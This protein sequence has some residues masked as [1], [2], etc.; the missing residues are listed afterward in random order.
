LHGLPINGGLTGAEA[1]NAYRILQ[2]FDPTLA[3]SSFGIIQTFQLAHLRKRRPGIGYIIRR[4][5]S[6]SGK[7]KS[8]K[9]V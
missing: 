2:Q 1:R 7:M 6:D 4:Q 5:D 3:W 8:R 9:G